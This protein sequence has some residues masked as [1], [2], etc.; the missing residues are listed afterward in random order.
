[1]GHV[2]RTGEKRNAHRVLMG[3]F[4]VKRQLGRTRR[5]LESKIK[6]YFKQIRWERVDWIDLAQVPNQW[7]AV[8]NTVMNLMFTDPCIVI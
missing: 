2:A 7:W 6:I 5:W 8:V 3:K 4:E 1:V